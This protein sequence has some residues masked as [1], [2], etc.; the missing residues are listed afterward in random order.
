MIH[1]HNQNIENKHTCGLFWKGN[2]KRC[3]K[4]RENY[5]ERLTY[6]TPNKSYN[7]QENK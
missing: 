1:N 5:K 3:S 2:R 4:F 6:S 7:I